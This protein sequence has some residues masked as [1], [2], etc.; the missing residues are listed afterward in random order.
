[1]RVGVAAAEPVVG[2]GTTAAVPFVTG[3]VGGAG[4][5][6]GR[7]RAGAGGSG[8]RSEGGSASSD[9]CGKR[10]GLHK[11]LAG[12]TRYDISGT[13]VGDFSGLLNI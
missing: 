10:N 11:V 4:M 2:V 1:M 6:G 13:S 8:P 7:R 12:E 3:M 9:L 5:M